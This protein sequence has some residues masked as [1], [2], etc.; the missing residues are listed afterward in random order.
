MV[1]SVD[2]R[3]SGATDQQIEASVERRWPME[4]RGQR[5]DIDA[6]VNDSRVKFAHAAR[7]LVPPTHRIVPVDDLKRL[8]DMACQLRMTSDEIDFLQRIDRS[9]IQPS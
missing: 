9:L 5:R 8:W 7:Y 6:F 3:V 4:L 1:M 2:E